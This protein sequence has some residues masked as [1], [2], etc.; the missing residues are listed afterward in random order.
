MRNKPEALT[1]TLGKHYNK[2]NILAFVQHFST[3]NVLFAGLGIGGRALT[4]FETIYRT[5]FDYV[6]YAALGIL[7]S[8]EAATDAAQSVFLR[9]MEKEKTLSAMRQAQVRSYLF[10]AVR[11]EC[12][13]EL[14][15]L[16]RELARPEPI[17]PEAPDFSA[18]PEEL[19]L[20]GEAKARLSALIGD[21]PAKYRAV[22]QLYYFAG[23]PQKEIAG[24][25]GIKE[26][27]LRSQLLR[28]KAM[29]Y[30]KFTQ[31]ERRNGSV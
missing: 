16:R 2:I 9:A 14:R 24:L 13:D 31:E 3:S 10:V 30:D 8:E 7:H 12:F 22:I 25:L 6:Y 18:L 1:H 28:A 27:T 4:D 17:G 11:N 20:Q 21:L 15:R 5:H 23:M 19:L 29:L 26:A